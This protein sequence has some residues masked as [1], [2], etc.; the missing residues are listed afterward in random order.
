[1]VAFLC[2]RRAYLLVMSGHRVAAAFILVRLLLYIYIDLLVL[3]L[4]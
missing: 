3:L 2:L 1:M 4:W